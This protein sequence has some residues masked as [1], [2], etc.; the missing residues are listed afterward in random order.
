[1]T[2]VDKKPEFIL[3]HKKNGSG[4]YTF[5]GKRDKKSYKGDTIID[6]NSLR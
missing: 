5:N 6:F 2:D 1:V 3:L 4:A